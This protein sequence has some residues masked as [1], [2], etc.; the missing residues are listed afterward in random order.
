MSRYA[1]VI[2][3]LM[4]SIAKVY[5]Q[6]GFVT[7][8]DLYSYCTVSSQPQCFGYLQG[9]ADAMSNGT[10][11]GWRACIPYQV[12]TYQLRDIAVQ[13]LYKNASK[14]QYNAASLVGAAFAE[15]FPCPG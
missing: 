12:S 5:G 3:A 14:R 6:A 1:A 11:F 2:I 4:V 10:V 9:I 15:S 8:N 13:Y 7:G